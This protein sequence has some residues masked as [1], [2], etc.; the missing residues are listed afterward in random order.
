VGSAG[1]VASFVVTARDAAGNIV[2]VLPTIAF[3]PKTAVDASSLQVI[4][5]GCAADG[6]N[7]LA[8]VTYTPKL[9]GNINITISYGSSGELRASR[10]ILL[11]SIPKPGIWMRV[12]ESR[13]M[14][15]LPF[16]PSRSIL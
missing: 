12:P 7:C 6:T 11:H 8:S 4:F 13:S 15:V 5:T 16:N 1:Q 10:L 2:T 3:T 9:Y 14:F